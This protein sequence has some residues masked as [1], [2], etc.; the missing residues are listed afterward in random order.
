MTKDELLQNAIDIAVAKAVIEERQRIKAQYKKA[1][2]ELR[3]DI[4]KYRKNNPGCV[5]MNAVTI[6]FNSKMQEIL[7][8]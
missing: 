3:E 2:D 4:Y 5:F 8:K 7:K 1:Y 6:V